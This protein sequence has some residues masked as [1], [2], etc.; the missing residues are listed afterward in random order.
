LAQII[1]PPTS[2]SQQWGAQVRITAYGIDPL[3]SRLVVS[4][5][6]GGFVD[7]YGLDPLNITQWVYQQRLSLFSTF[8]I[9]GMAIAGGGSVIQINFRGTFNATGYAAVAISKYIN[10]SVGYGEFAYIMPS[11]G[12][13]NST[14][15]L[16]LS[17]NDY[18]DALIIPRTGASPILYDIYQNQ[19]P[20]ADVGSWTYSATVPAPPGSTTLTSQGQSEGDAKS[21]T[22]DCSLIIAGTLTALPP[23]DESTGFVAIYRTSLPTCP[24]LPPPP[25]PP[26]EPPFDP[27]IDPPVAPVAPVDP[28]IDPPVAPINPPVAPID[29]PVDPPVAPIDP[30]V[31]PPV[32]PVDPPIAPIEPPMPPAAPPIAPPVVPPAAPQVTPPDDNPMAPPANPTGV[33]IGVTVSSIVVVFIAIIVVSQCY[34]NTSKVS[35]ATPKPSTALLNYKRL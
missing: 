34:F 23:T 3:Q 1:A 7:I 31:A 20:S 9:D 5:L 26:I 33:I 14:L 10:S 17:T 21:L 2:V 25:L 11:A 6:N 12:N 29:P 15:G 28:P 30:P 13:T 8:F 24:V 27:P 35:K 16:A 18:G 22:A 19:Q 4:S 32:A